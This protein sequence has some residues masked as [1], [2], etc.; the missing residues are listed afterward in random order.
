MSN[1]QELTNLDPR[2]VEL[3]EHNR[4]TRNYTPFT[5]HLFQWHSKYMVKLIAEASKKQNN[6]VLEIGSGPRDSVERRVKSMPK[7]WNYIGVEVDP[8]FVQE[9]SA[10]IGHRLSKD[11]SS[12]N[13]QVRRG[14]GNKPLNE[15][16]VLE[17]SMDA[18]IVNHMLANA[19]PHEVRSYIDN[20]KRKLKPNSPPSQ[21]IVYMEQYLNTLSDDYPADTPLADI[22]QNMLIY[23]NVYS[24]LRPDGVFV[25]GL[26]DQ[27]FALGNAQQTKFLL[28]DMGFKNVRIHDPA[29]N[30][31][32]LKDF[33]FGKPSKFD[34]A[35]ISAHKP[36]TD[37]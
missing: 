26:N 37:I 34:T 4:D 28:H 9:S 1:E 17:N 6:Q 36:K 11:P 5:E 7:S 13:I 8:L 31:L 18:A 35:I 2:I 16:G 10:F 33:S 25:L 15:F 29:Y 32:N 12:S 14:D 27:T 22:Y 19:T 24:A 23:S 3:R 30:L 21:P 20:Y